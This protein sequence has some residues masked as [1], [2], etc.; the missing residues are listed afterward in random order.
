MTSS[1]CQILNLSFPTLFANNNNCCVSVSGVLC[2]N[3]RVTGLFLSKLGIAGPLPPQLAALDRLTALDLSSNQLSGPIPSELGYLTLL[4][5]LNLSNNLLSGSTPSFFTASTLNIGQN[6]FTD[7]TNLNPSC[8]QVPA[9]TTSSGSVIPTVINGVSMIQT[10]TVVPTTLF[11]VQ[12]NGNAPAVL[13]PVPTLVS[14]TTLVSYVP[15]PPTWISQHVVPVAVGAGVGALVLIFVIFG[16]VIWRRKSA[17]AKGS[18]GGNDVYE[19]DAFVMDEQQQ[20]QQPS[21][22][23]NL[24][25]QKLQQYSPLSPS[26]GDIGASQYQMPRHHNH[27]QPQLSQ[28]IQQQQPQFTGSHFYESSLAQTSN[29]RQ[30]PLYDANQQYM[31][32]PQGDGQNHQS[33]R[34]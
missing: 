25:P 24:P 12:K 20:S 4:T 13:V 18:K 30:Q 28:P 22:Q 33:R 11:Q 16:C 15:P 2:A 8:P 26:R 31:V 29:Q 32:A 5:T 17:R 21:R 34:N 7:S 9:T 3:D 27:Q 1:D 23:H 10:V 19:T 14:Q 6:C